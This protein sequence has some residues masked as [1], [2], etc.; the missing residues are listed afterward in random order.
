[1]PPSLTV[2]AIQMI[3]SASL[4]ENLGVATRL[5]SEAADAGAKV[6]A[7]PEYF[8][9]M[10]LKDTDKV[11]IREAYGNGPIQTAMQELAQQHQVHLIA[12]TIPLEAS[13][14]QKVLNT[15]LVFYKPI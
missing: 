14:R 1:M 11:A 8:C 12:G 5:I 15:T 10:G 2:A 13:D 4:A 6:I 7:L 3:S 9:L